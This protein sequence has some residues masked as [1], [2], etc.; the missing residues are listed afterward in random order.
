MPDFEL[1][2]T[3]LATEKTVSNTMTILMT[4]RVLCNVSQRILVSYS[5]RLTQTEMHLKRDA[6]RLQEAE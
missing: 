4:S 6:I 2:H 1:V 3:F 5:R